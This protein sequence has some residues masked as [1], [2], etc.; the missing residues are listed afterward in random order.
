MAETGPPKRIVRPIASAK[1]VALPPTRTV[2]SKPAKTFSVGTGQGRKMGEKILIYADTGMG[3]STLASMAP[4]P[5]FIDPDNGCTDLINPTTGTKVKRVQD[6]NGNPPSDF[7]DIRSALHDFS[8]YDDRETVV[9][10]NATVIQDAAVP[11]MLAT[12]PNDKGT[13]MKNIVAYGYNKGYQHLYDTMKLILQDCDMLCQRGKN[14]IIIAQS[15]PNKVSNPGG[16]DYLREGPRLYS[17]K[18]ANIEALYCEWASHILRI[19]YQGVWAGKDKKATGDTTRIIYTQPEVHFRAKSRIL[20]NGTNLEPIIS[21]SEP[22]DDS[23]WKFLF[24]GK[25]D[26][27][28]N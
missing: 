1:K 6:E 11:Y 4:D 21:F 16:E 18:D 17:S 22:S 14:V 10:D 5:I 24:P 19:D 3:K 26:N 9:L 28:N 2:I 8:L 20:A 12:I 13:L 7:D 15:A 27:A 23:L 25:V